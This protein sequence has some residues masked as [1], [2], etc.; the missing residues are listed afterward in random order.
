MRIPFLVILSLAVV[1]T[2]FGQTAAKRLPPPGIDV[3]EMVREALQSKLRE[4]Q[5]EIAA[6]DAEPKSDWH[7]AHLPDARVYEKAV[8]YALEHN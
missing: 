6:V 8:R 1:A 4:L 3:P 2:S 5:K 7:D